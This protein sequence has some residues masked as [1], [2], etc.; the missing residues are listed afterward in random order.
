MEPTSERPY[1]RPGRLGKALAWRLDRIQSEYL[2]GAP[3]ARADLARLRRGL[4]KRVG[5]VPEIWELTVGAVPEHLAGRTRPSA[6]EQAA[7]AA[8]TLYAMHQQSASGPMH[9]SG[10]S[11]GEAVGRLRS[12][13][14]RSEEA[15][16]RRFM[17]VATSESPEELLMHV[18]GLIAQLRSA[19]VGFDYSLFAGDVEDLLRRDRAKA[20]RL[21]WGRDYYRTGDDGG[22]REAAASAE[23]ATT[24]EGK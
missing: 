5:D 12:H 2:S 18:R 14:D 17:A 6:A 1:R 22:A 8:L 23:A 9:V 24:T 10:V 4:G 11:F 20:V 15:V 13:G 3:A 7:H 19:G 21:R 16:T